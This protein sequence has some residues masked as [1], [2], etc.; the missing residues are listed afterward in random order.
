MSVTSLVSHFMRER[1]ISL[2]GH[3]ASVGPMLYQKVK[4]KQF[5]TE[6]KVYYLLRVKWMYSKEYQYDS[7]LINA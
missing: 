7:E 6:L 1:K 5:N 2:A 4:L 3:F